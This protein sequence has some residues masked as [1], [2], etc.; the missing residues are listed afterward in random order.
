VPTVRRPGDR[1]ARPLTEFGVDR[2]TSYVR[3]TAVGALT[4]TAAVVEKAR[5]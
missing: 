1:Y 4:Q 3:A 5:S 2:S